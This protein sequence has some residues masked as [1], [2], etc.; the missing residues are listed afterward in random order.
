MLSEGTFRVGA[1][2]HFCA[3]P[4]WGLIPLLYI[5]QVSTLERAAGSPGGQIGSGA[6]L[7]QFL[8]ASF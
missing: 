4:A 1:S 6:E 3:L 5:A 2:C 8:I 7:Q